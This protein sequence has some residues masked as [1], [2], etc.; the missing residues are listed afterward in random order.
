M[1]NTYTK[2]YIHLVW[3]TKHRERLISN[4]TKPLVE[5]LIVG[6]AKDCS[7]IPIAVYAMP[8]HIHLLVAVPPT[9]SISDVV[10]HIKRRSSKIHNENQGQKLY[11]QRGFGA[12][13]V[14]HLGL[15]KV[16]EYIKNQEEHHTKVNFKREYLQW[17]NDW[18]VD[19]EMQYVFD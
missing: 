17:L 7:L 10:G 5:K 11:W 18:N 6:I 3:S 1:S 8:D 9:R 4:K 14:S 2:C 16:I 19:Y 15:E 13:S 12:F